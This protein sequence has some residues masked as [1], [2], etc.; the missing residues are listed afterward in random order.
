MAA[1]TPNVLRQYQ[2]AVRNFQVSPYM[3]YPSHVHMETFSRCTAA[4]NFCPYTS[5]DRIG[6]R[7]SDALIEKI[8]TDLTDIPRHVP[9]QI[10]PFKVNEPFLDTRLFD[11]LHTINQR[12]PHAEICL[13]SNASP[14]TERNLS[15]LLQVERVKYLWIS[16]N[17]H[18][19]EH[20]E[21][22]MR[23]PWKRTQERLTMIH[24]AL[25]DGR[26]KFRV[27]LSRVGD[28]SPADLE[29]MQWVSQ[30]FP[31]F[32]TH[33]FQRGGWLGQANIELNTPVPPTGCIRWFELSITST[34]KVAHCCMDG[35]AEWP[36]GDVNHQHM[37][38]VYNNPEYRA[39]REKTR[40]RME[41]SPCNTCTFL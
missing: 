41:V 25:A 19:P 38:E 24:K 2:T 13:T 14:I 15:K 34:G 22:T 31:L 9:F 23:L 3:Q 37:L 7:M 36:I 21:Q 12:L 16:F 18:R 27:V 35:K 33:I 40:S 20:Y 32:Q 5:L 26:L 6:S 1:A 11:I 4:C 10:S 17:D 30:N 39:L 29:F 8:I 28:N